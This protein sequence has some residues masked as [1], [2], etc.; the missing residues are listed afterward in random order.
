MDKKFSMYDRVFYTGRQ[1]VGTIVAMSC[2][3]YGVEF[4]EN[5]S[6]HSLDG[7]CDPGHGLWCFGSNLELVDDCGDNSKFE[8]DQD[9]FQGL[10]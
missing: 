2:G 10:F 8:F 1:K 9:A 4:D 3:M 6:G 5:V 7:A